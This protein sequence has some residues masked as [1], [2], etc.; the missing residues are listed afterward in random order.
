VSRNV[1]RPS[2]HSPDSG[3]LVASRAVRGCGSAIKAGAPRLSIS[4]SGR[5]ADRPRL[6]NFA[7][8]HGLI[9][10]GGFLS[11]LLV[12]GLLGLLCR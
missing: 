10:C 5:R 2:S 4:N 7:E 1:S 9:H 11:D 3:G 8:S 6:G 12:F